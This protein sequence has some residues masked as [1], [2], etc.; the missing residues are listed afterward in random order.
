MNDRN[1]RKRNPENVSNSFDH[2]EL[3]AL[4]V[5]QELLMRGGDARTIMRS[6]EYLAGVGKL[7]R[8]LKRVEL[9]MAEAEL[10]AVA[11]KPSKAA[12]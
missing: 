2:K 4:V 12:S 8:M 1:D 7:Q 5:V 11:P 10:A 9:N 3:R 6:P